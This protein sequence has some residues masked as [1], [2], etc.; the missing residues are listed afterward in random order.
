MFILPILV[1]VP[2]PSFEELTFNF[3]GVDSDSTDDWNSQLD[4]KGVAERLSRP[5]FV[6]LKRVCI[7]WPLSHHIEQSDVE[8]LLETGPFSPITRRGL[9]QLKLV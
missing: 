5:Q 9:V 2:S 6:N 8:W 4:W 1:Q 3:V 7:E